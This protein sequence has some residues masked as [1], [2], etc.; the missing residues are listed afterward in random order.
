MLSAKKYDVAFSFAGEERHFV[1][2][3]ANV[4]A[5]RR[6]KV[7]YDRYEQIQLWGKNL[8]EELDRVYRL[9]SDCVVVFISKA[10]AEKVWTH[11]EIRS[12][13]AVAL[14][15]SAPYLLP[16]RFDDTDLLGVPPTI[17]YIDLRNETPA[18]FAQKV[19]E[20][21]SQTTTD[22]ESKT[23]A[24]TVVFDESYGKWQITPPDT[25]GYGSVLKSLSKIANVLP[26]ENGY[27]IPASLDNAHILILPTPRKTTIDE[28]EIDVISKWVSGG[29]RLL[30]MGIYLAEAH[31]ENNI[32]SLTRRFGLKFNDDLIMPIARF[33]DL[34]LGQH[35]NLET[36]PQHFA[37]CMNQAFAVKDRDSCVL[38]RPRAVPESHPILDSVST[39][40]LTSS[41]TVECVNP[42]VT[43]YTS[44]PAAILHAVGYEGSS[45]RL[46]RIERYVLDKR[47]PAPFMVAIRHRAGKVVGV[48]TWKAFLNDLIVG[49]DDNQNDILFR[50]IIGWLRTG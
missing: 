19:V 50:N 21:L 14:T 5:E 3:V 32:N 29:G 15:A 35:M 49:S 44:D 33:Q 2:Q 34:P 20:K 25:D 46:L 23:G 4:L 13:L 7:F 22:D 8:S 41:C 45:G 36:Y 16:A 18:T 30:V 42:D 17:G 11:F 39:V 31:H 10:Y 1:Q 48:G 12:V 43:V 37:Y 27:L 28:R 24:L 38:S 26:H 47:G 9:E 6:I 40:A